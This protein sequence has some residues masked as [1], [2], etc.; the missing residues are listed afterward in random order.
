MNTKGSWM[1]R[2]TSTARRSGEGEWKATPLW[3]AIGRGKNLKLAKYLLAR[4][5][6]PEH[7]MWATAFNDRPASIRLLVGAGAVVDVRGGE[8]PFLFAVKWNHFAAIPSTCGCSST[9][10]RGWISRTTRA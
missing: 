9:M 1:P 10:A 8:T 4:G 6:D 5:A 3:Y 7:C 2:S